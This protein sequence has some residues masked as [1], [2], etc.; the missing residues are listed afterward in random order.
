VEGVLSGAGLSIGGIVEAVFLP[1]D[2][3]LRK[4][5]QLPE[6]VGRKL[7]GIDPQRGVGG[8]AVGGEE[9]LEILPQHGLHTG[10]KEGGK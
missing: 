8:L 1:R 7:Q 3:M 10:E 5:S 6:A 2:G 4:G 9:G